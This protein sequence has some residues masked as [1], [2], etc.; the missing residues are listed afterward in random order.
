MLCE[1]GNWVGGMKALRC[2][3]LLAYVREE[4]LTLRIREVYDIG[5]DVCTGTRR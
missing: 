4:V 3:W 1:C 5:L 2:I